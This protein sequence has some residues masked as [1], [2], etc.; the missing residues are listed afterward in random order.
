MT[1]LFYSWTMYRPTLRFHN[2][3]ISW[4]SKYLY[5]P[6][7]REA[8]L[9]APNSYLM[10]LHWPQIA[11]HTGSQKLA[12]QAALITL[13]SQ[14]R[15]FDNTSRHRY[16]L[17]GLSFYTIDATILLSAMAVMYPPSNQAAKINIHQTLQAPAT[18]QQIQNSG[19]H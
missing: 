2:P 11:T 15:V 5:L 7:Q 8:I 13:G 1:R 10:A 3:D 19:G 16:K 6:Q 12:L 14:Q 18:Y 17:F 4:D 9:T